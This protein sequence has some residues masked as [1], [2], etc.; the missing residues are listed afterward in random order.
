MTVAACTA[1]V[2]FAL[3]WAALVEVQEKVSGTG[4]IEPQ[5]QIERIEHP[6]GGVVRLLQAENNATV[7][8]GAL[9]LHFE[10]DHIEREALSLAARIETLEEE[11]ARVQFLLHAD[12]QAL[13]IIRGNGDPGSEAFWAEQVFFVAQL[14]RITAEDVGLATQVESARARAKTIA[15]EQKIVQDQIARYGRYVDSGTVRLIDRERLQR[16]ALQ[17]SRT[18]EEIEGRRIELENTRTENARRRDELL[19]Q[20]RRDAAVRWT[21]VEEELTTLRQGAADAAARIDRAEVRTTVGGKI[22]RLEV[23]RAN[24]V[25]APGDVIA[26]IVPPGTSYRAVVNIS[27]DRIGSI[28]HGMKVDLKVVSYDFT[29][30]GSISAMVSEVSPTSFIDETGEVV[31]RVTVNLPQSVPTGDGPVAVR[32]GMTVTADILTGERSVLNYLLKPVRR[33]QDQSLTET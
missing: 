12:G 31:F 9:L 21:K 24:E 25:V 32:P 29:R 11:A 33:I 3:V 2:A 22:L 30:F 10:T 17:L 7:P 23:L 4:T 27:A 16:D 14:D 13:P 5:G 8:P 19:A 6:D 20:R 28:R 18:L 15:Q 1:G 26:E